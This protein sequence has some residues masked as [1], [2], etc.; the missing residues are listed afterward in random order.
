[1]AGRAR[2]SF[3]T[4]LVRLRSS[5]GLT[6]EELAEASGVAV[7]TI[8]D[9]ERGVALR[10][11]RDTVRRL[12][13][14]LGLGGQALVEFEAASR[15]H[16]LIGGAKQA[17]SGRRSA[18]G[19]RPATRM[20][21]RDIAESFTARE[22]E[23]VQLAEA[24][25]TADA[26]SG[27]VPVSVIGGMAGIG[28]TSLAVHAAHLL[29][30]QFPDGQLFINLHGFTEGIEPLAPAEALG[31]LLRSLYM[32]PHLIPRSKDERAA[33]F[34]GRLAGT[35]TLIVLDNAVSSA[36]VRPLLPGTGGCMVLVTSREWLTGLDDA[37]PI[38][39]SM[40]TG[41]EAIALF[42]AIAGAERIAASDP[43]LPG[44]VELCGY[45]PLAVRIIAARMNGPRAAS[46]STETVLEE[47]RQARGSLAHI[48]DEDRSL[49]G[50]FES[51]YRN[52]MPA[53]QD[54]FRVLGLVPGPDF[55]AYA[56]A[57][58]ASVDVG[59]AER[60]LESLLRQNLLIQHTVGRFFFHD[61]IRVYA[62]GLTGATEAAMDRLL[63]YYLQASWGAD[64][65]F[66]R[67]I[68]AVGG[69]ASLRPAPVAAPDLVTVG[70]AV[71]WMSAEL[72]SLEAAADYAAANE[73]PEQAI[74]L[75]AA[76]AQYLRAHG[77]WTRALAMHGRALRLATAIGDRAGQAQAL[78]FLGVIQRQAGAFQDA[79]ASLTRAAELFSAIG[80]AGSYASVLIE[81]A[82]AL[83]LTSALADA[84]RDLDDA[85]G[86]YRTS[87]DQL[88]RAAALSELG[89]IQRQRGEFAEAETSL[90]EALTSY[91]GNLPGEAAAHA[92][93][94]SVYT[95][96]GDFASAADSLTSSL[97]LF[98]ILED[99]TGQANCLL[100]LGMGHRA[101][102]DWPAAIDTL[103]SALR[104][105]QRLGDL[106]GQAGARSFLGAV[107]LAAADHDRAGESLSEAL[108]L[109]RELGDTG[110]A[111]ETLNYYGKLAAATIGPTQ[112]RER[113]TE[114]LN[115]ARRIGS[116]RDEADA[117][118]GIAASYRAD[119]DRQQA[120]ACYRQALT[121][122]R[123]LNCEA[124]AARVSAALADLTE[125]LVGGDSD[126]GGSHAADLAG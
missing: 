47:L 52:L 2:S 99:P 108:R 63:G 21:P 79:L 3:G 102:A 30:E 13:T 35:R 27:R 76:T 19:I 90:A 75:S 42:R 8:S 53:E 74:A 40:L 114:A 70:D 24:A 104:L 68:P 29:A 57:S 88:G 34:R 26:G 112:A 50:A 45:L 122:Y 101:T 82:I 55:D 43:F 5:A 16:A 119:S 62:R 9:L 98:R 124:D 89:I 67:R 77:P 37:L 72:A 59:V 105:Y 61:L 83:R 33:V 49:V 84:E 85:L 125:A 32:P 44:I 115:L 69:S 18:D 80:D 58:L 103:S 14:A 106:R 25:A 10:P 56:A 54:A 100:Y 23:L 86:A 17:A 94:G 41:P 60:L 113:H 64:K 95:A 92:Y 118:D 48:R 6:H 121:L 20:L 111:A 73:R 11:H 71:T 81:R 107:Q 96:T 91:R 66:E 78:A 4:L 116:R 120:S 117:L 123:S 15:Q 51:S 87:G 31:S 65:L 93:L 22:A 1:M 39:L 7:R 110:G 46:I 12:A 97:E 38:Q 28:K 36:Q 109:F 126:C